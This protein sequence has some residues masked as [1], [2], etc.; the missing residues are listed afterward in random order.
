MKAEQINPNQIR[1]LL[2]SSDLAEKGLQVKDLAYGSEKTKALFDDMMA[3][4][5]DEFGF[6]PGGRPLMIE[7]IPLSEE[8]LMIT[9]TKVSGAAERA[10]LAG[11]NIPGLGRPEANT[12]Q[13]TADELP[14]FE[15]MLDRLGLSGETQKG[16]SGA[17]SL[18]RPM[19]YIFDRFESLTAAAARIPASTRLKNSLYHEEKG[20]YYL[21]VDYKKLDKTARFV[22][23]VLS[24]FY[25]DV[26][27]IPYGELLM[28]EHCTAVIKARA[29]QKLSELEN[30]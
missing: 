23:N 17:E 22:M 25:D 27:D 10:G 11:S 13:E 30:V 8:S 14:S 4:A 1:F 5:R 18:T 12:P 26:M 2:G 28:K 7:A 16:G 21:L 19:I 6:E 24:E 3:H 20:S 29:L 15:D 9:V